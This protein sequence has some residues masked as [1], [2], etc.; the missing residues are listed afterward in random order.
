MIESLRAQTKCI[1]YKNESWNSSDNDNCL[2]DNNVVDTSFLKLRL[3]IVKAQQEIGL[4]LGEVLYL[5]C[6]HWSLLGVNINK[7][8]KIYF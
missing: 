3:D 6:S 7:I 5:M 8:V 1:W 4:V 2:E